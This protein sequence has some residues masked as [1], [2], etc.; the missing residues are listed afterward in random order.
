[1][2]WLH[3][4][5]PTFLHLDLKPANL[6]VD[7]N[8]VVKVADFGMSQIKG[9]SSGGIFGSPFYMAP[10]MLLEKG[11][12]EKVDVYS[13]G[14]VLWE[15]VTR[16]EPYEGLFKNFD[17]LADGVGLE[18]IRP[19]IPADVHPTLKELIT[20]LWDHDPRRRPS[21]ADVRARL[22]T[23]LRRLTR[24][25]PQLDSAHKRTRQCSVEYLDH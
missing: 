24:P 5:K 17:Q 22:P 21:F 3:S 10:E 2:N 9:A 13:F 8:W 16:A 19:R 14:I 11:F 15:M 4:Q 12:D 1:M 6:L 23:R 25:S 7:Q 18:K 20:Q